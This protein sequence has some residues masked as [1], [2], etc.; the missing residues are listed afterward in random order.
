MAAEKMDSLYVQTGFMDFEEV[1]GKR[2]TWEQ[3]MFS[4][5]PRGGMYYHDSEEVAIKWLSLSN[6]KFL[7]QIDTWL[8]TKPENQHEVLR[9]FEKANNDFAIRPRI[10]IYRFDRYGNP[11]AEMT[12]VIV[13]ATELR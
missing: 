6:D 3:V 1:S 2:M 10:S 13:S 11:V 7:L 12:G 4:T 8:K 5:Q 9:H